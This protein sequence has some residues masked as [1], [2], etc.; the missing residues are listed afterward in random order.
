ML[1]PRRL[2]RDMRL[3]KGRW[4]R[5]LRMFDCNLGHGWLTANILT[6]LLLD[7]SLVLRDVYKRHG[8]DGRNGLSIQHL[9]FHHLT[10]CPLYSHCRR[11]YTPS[12]HLCF[13][14]LFILDCFGSIYCIYCISSGTT[15]IKTKH[16]PRSTITRSTTK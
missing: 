7:P 11:I 8:L 1:R 9:T 5:L 2:N 10:I 4:L 15:Y 12:Y 13:Y 3:G 14:R 6:Y 16:R